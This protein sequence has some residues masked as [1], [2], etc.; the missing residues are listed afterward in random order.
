MRKVAVVG[1]SGRQGGAQ[2]RQ[3][4]KAGFAVKALSRSEDPFYGEEKPANVEV[5]PADL[6]DHESLVAAFDG[7]EAVFHTHPLRARADRAQIAGSV[8]KAAKEAGVKRVVWNTSSWIPDRPGDPFTYGGNTAGINALWRSGVG[9]TVFGSVLFMDNL[10]TNWVK[11]YLL[12]DNEFAYPHKLDLDVS[13]ICLDDVARFM[14]EAA[15]REDLA[16]EIIDVG[17]PQT[18]RPTMVAELLSEALGR[19]ITYRL[20]TPRE[21]GERMYEVFKD[22]AGVTREVYV[23]NLEKHYLYKNETNPFLVPM[24]AMLKRIP[25][26][27]TPMRDWLG[28]QDWSARTADQVGSVSG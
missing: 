18:L 6:Y 16:G 4:V 10:L 13:W 26:T 2:V 23:G 11:P 5:V 7:A 14:I 12:R 1:A 19:R 28:Q 9:A 17:G 25:I 27:L 21:F 22:V 3:L 8:G 24:D 20:I 15:R